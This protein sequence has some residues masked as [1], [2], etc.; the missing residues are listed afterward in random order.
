[1]I[2]CA[3]LLTCFC[4]PPPDLARIGPL[5][6]ALEAVL[7]EA[8]PLGTISALFEVIAGYSTPSNTPGLCQVKG[9][10]LRYLPSL[11][12]EK[13]VWHQVVKPEGSTYGTKAS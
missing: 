7:E 3:R 2:S 11:T 12:S 9:W 10:P 1:M 4:A 5:H 8:G 6:V 13:A